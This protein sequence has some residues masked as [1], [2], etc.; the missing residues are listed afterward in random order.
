MTEEELAAHIKQLE[1]AVDEADEE[2]G[3]YAGQTWRESLAAVKAELDRLRAQVAKH[4][5]LLDHLQDEEAKAAQ[6]TNRLRADNAA[7]RLVMARSYADVIKHGDEG[8]CDC[9]TCNGV[10]EFMTE[11]EARALLA[12]EVSTE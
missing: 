6:E 2:F 10:Y 1:V 4:D 8:R 7:M 5:A 11:E 12:K 3:Y 9:W